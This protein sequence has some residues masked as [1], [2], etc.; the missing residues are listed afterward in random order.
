MNKIIIKNIL[1][2][3]NLD[4][5]YCNLNKTSQKKIE[6]TIN[7]IYKKLNEIIDYINKGK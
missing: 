5:I 4:N 6:K 2:D 7:D 1:N 3:F